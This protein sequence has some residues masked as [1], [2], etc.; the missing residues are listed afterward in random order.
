[1]LHAICQGML[2]T[3]LR[4]KWP[5]A[6]GDGVRKRLSWPGWRHPAL[7]LAWCGVGMALGIGLALFLVAP[8]ASPFLLASLGGSA[9]FL[10][11]MS[12]APAAQPRAL[13]GGHL[14]CAC[15]GLA[16]HQWLGDS[17]ASMATAQVLAL[18]YMLLTRT[19]H[20]PAGANPLLMVHMHAQWSALWGTVL[21]GV[22]ALVVVAWCWSR[23]YPELVHYPVAPLAPSPSRPLWGGWPNPDESAPST[24]PS[25]RRGD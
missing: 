10:F 11:G 4:R 1:M 3:L 17:L 23:C 21:P 6:R 2:D 8:P 12:R 5:P 7:R 24:A 18:L 19:L 16:C 15:I 14:G 13:L 25:P 22:G 20:P 9:V